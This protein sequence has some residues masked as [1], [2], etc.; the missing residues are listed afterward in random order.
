MSALYHVSISVSHVSS[1]LCQLIKR[2]YEWDNK[3]L[4]SFKGF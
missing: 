2:G 1:Q 3:E 4:W